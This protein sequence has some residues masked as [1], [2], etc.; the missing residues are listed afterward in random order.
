M[1]HGFYSKTEKRYWASSL[2]A[3]LD[4]KVLQGYPA[5]YAQISEAYGALKLRG[6]LPN[7]RA[8]LSCEGKNRS[9][10]VSILFAWE[11]WLVLAHIVV[12]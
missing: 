8:H 11:V 6:N 4:S 5:R 7:A 10:F 1:V 2:H 3:A 9:M 12:M